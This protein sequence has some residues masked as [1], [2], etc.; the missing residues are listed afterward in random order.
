MKEDMVCFQGPVI[1]GGKTDISLA[2]WTTISS[3]MGISQRGKVRT[4]RVHNQSGLSDKASLG[5]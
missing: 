4:V 1:L 2:E 5:K 3:E